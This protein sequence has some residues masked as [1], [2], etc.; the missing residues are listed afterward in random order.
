MAGK[1][2]PGLVGSGKAGPGSARCGRQ[3]MSR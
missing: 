1:A 3:G 2:R